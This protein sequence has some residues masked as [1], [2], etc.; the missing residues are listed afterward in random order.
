[1]CKFETPHKITVQKCYVVNKGKV[2][3]ILGLETVKDLNIIK[4]QDVNKILDLCESYENIKLQNV[5]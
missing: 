5:S 1:M 2:G 4:L 3:N